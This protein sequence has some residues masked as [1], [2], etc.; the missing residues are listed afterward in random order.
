MDG[1]GDRLRAR[2]MALGLSD[3]EVARRSGLDARRYGHYVRGLH[4]PDLTT[5]VRIAGVLETTPDGLLISDPRPT[6]GASA[7][8]VRAAAMTRLIAM[9]DVLDD[10]DLALATDHVEVIVRHR[11]RA[12]RKQEPQ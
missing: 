7:S 2:A 6:S 8:S 1:L 12:A 5:L 10:D 3:A 11:Q 4:E 9:A